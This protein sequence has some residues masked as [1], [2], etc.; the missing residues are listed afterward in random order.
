MLYRTSH[1]YYRGPGIGGLGEWV[2]TKLLDWDVTLVQGP[3]NRAV[4]E[5]V[6]GY[7]PKEAKGSDVN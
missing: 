2:D 1:S 7:S 4:C 6:G 5:W 3:G